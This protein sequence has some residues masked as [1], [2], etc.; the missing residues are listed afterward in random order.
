MKGNKGKKS[1][2]IA[3]KCQRQNTM[4]RLFRGNLTY[5]AL[6]SLTEPLCCQNAFLFTFAP[7]EFHECTLGGAQRENFDTLCRGQKM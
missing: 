1:R 7:S 4:R 6:T 3:T 2:Y 5:L